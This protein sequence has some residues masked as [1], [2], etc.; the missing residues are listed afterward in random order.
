MSEKELMRVQVIQA[1]CDKRLRRRDA[2]TQLHLSE[3]QVQRLMEGFVCHFR[4]SVFQDFQNGLS[5]VNTEYL[6]NITVHKQVY[7]SR[8][9]PADNQ[10]MH[11]YL[12]VSAVKSTY[13]PY[14]YCDT[15]FE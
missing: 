3:R 12:I 9:Y 15:F 5:C 7:C 8:K 11:S 10:L 1:V 2:A 4:D 6:C 14:P 13:F